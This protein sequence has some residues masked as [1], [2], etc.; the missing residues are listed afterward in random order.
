MS[1]TGHARSI[2]FFLFWM[3]SANLLFNKM[4]I[5]SNLGAKLEPEIYVKK[6]NYCST[7]FNY[8]P[9]YTDKVELDLSY[10]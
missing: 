4:D 5:K 1:I 3:R 9:N 8:S 10:K 2:S 6:F 7:K